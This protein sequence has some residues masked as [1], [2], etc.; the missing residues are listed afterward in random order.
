MPTLK[1]FGQNEI[2]MYELNDS[3]LSDFSCMA[4]DG[5]PHSQIIRYVF[6]KHG[7]ISPPIM[8]HYFEAI[9]SHRAMQFMP[10]LGSWWH[11]TTSDISD[12]EFNRLINN[13]LEEK[14]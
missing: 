5:Y 4:K 7:E 11:D 9:Y 14:G 12:D 3:I 1:Q 2:Y 10:A 6:K 13:V 8:A